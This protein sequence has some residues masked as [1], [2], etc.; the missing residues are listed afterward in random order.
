MPVGNVVQSEQAKKQCLMVIAQVDKT[1]IN[2]NQSS[3]MD[4]W[5]SMYQSTMFYGNFY[6]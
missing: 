2:K 5:F 6:Q 3:V 4:G 1:K